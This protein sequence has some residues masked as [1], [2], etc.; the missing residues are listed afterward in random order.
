MVALHDRRPN[1]LRAPLVAS[2]LLQLFGRIHRLPARGVFLV[3]LAV[4]PAL[5]A[6]DYL[7]GAV[8]S[9]NIFYVL[10]V[11]AVSATGRTRYPVLIAVATVLAWGVVDAARDQGPVSS[12]AWNGVA[13]FGVLYLCAMLVGAV[14]A[15]ARVEHEMSRTDP[16]TGL[17]NQRGFREL[18]Q[19]E[20]ARAERRRAPCTLLYIDIDGFKGVNDSRGHA[21]GDELLV[22]VARTLSSSARQVDVVGRLG[23]DEFAVLLSDA[24]G[25]SASRSAHRLSGALDDL[26]TR[27]GWPVRFSIGVVTFM[28]HPASVDTLLSEADGLMYDAK[29]L[30]KVSARSTVV[31]GVVSGLS[32]ERRGDVAPKE[33]PSAR[34]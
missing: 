5:A 23:G 15:M 7:S 1:E 21:V 29:R 17:L 20:I 11:L 27:D 30:G 24:D 34:S 26:C 8:Y 28:E 2:M 10:V 14:A 32:V 9:I 31:T 18:T 3:G 22:D 33:S 12:L 16:L 4:V 19:R 25:R 6:V 13:R